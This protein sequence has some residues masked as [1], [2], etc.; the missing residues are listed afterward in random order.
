MLLTMVSCVLGRVFY[1]ILHRARG[2]RVKGW[3][4]EWAE[5]WAYYLFL[6]SISH[7]QNYTSKIQKNMIGLRSPENCFWFF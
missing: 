4:K 1:F 3:V 7:V 5:G 2:S 6:Y